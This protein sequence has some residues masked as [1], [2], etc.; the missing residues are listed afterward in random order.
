MSE[1]HA[2]AGLR[3]VLVEDE[4][5]IA[6]ALTDRLE[7]EGFRVTH[8][9]DGESG[10]R[11]AQDGSVAL[12]ILDL[13]L[14]KMNGTDVLQAIRAGGSPVAVIC[15]TAKA[16]E[17]DRVSHLAGGADDYLT[18][19]FSTDE[20]VARVRAVLRRTSA[21]SRVEAAGIVIDFD[22]HTVTHAATQNVAGELRIEKLSALEAGILRCLV[23]RRGK[24]T[25]RAQI[26][27][28]VWGRYAAV[29]DRTIDF[30][31]KNLRRKIEID[32]ES[33]RLLVTDHGV[34][35]RFTG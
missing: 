7:R 30:N 13:M 10:L 3:L 19:P 35:Y 31:V 15:L 14:P 23:T 27:D 33:P 17:R 22:G 16:S 1:P 8:C 34:G 2:A 28:A 4:P 29:T 20:L 6:L 21:P 18:K 24:A 11:A 26:L 9:A 12:V 32:P 25:S 5:A